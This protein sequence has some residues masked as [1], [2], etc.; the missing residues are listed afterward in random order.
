MRITPEAGF[1]GSDGCL[2]KM[3]CATDNLPQG[4]DI[5]SVRL[6]HETASDQT[7]IH[8]LLAKAD[9]QSQMMFRDRVQLANAG[10]FVTTNQA[11]VCSGTEYCMD[12]TTY[13]IYPVQE[14]DLGEYMCETQVRKGG[15]GVGLSWRLVTGGVQGLCPGTTVRT[16]SDPTLRRSST[17]SETTLL[18]RRRVRR[19]GSDQN[20]HGTGQRG[21]LSRQDTVNVT[22]VKLFQVWGPSKAVW[23][24]GLTDVKY[25]ESDLLA[26]ATA[27][28]NGGRFTENVVQANGGVDPDIPSDPQLCSCTDNCREYY[29]F[30][31]DPVTLNDEGV[32]A[33]VIDPRGGTGGFDYAARLSFSGDCPGPSREIV[34]D[35]NCEQV[36]FEKYVATSYSY[37]TE[38]TID[39]CD[40]FCARDD[41]S[42]YYYMD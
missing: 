14:K 39:Y 34:R 2:A 31:V 35:E 17:R 19:D 41:E 42:V 33:C 9:D 38:A 29:T 37:E 32:Y 21:S 8:T 1:H 24:T 4:S 11:P 26:Q 7:K 5:V 28:F 30:T 20:P 23:F 13:F 10:A 16:V 27:G 22:S 36:C 15:R 25:T 3:D 12:T 40:Q 18:S 6:Y